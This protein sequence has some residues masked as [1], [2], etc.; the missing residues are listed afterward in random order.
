MCRGGSIVLAAALSLGVLTGCD[1]KEVI[2]AAAEV[3]KMSAPVD[4][5]RVSPLVKERVFEMFAS[6]KRSPETRYE[7]SRYLEES[8]LR[9][10]AFFKGA[11]KS[12]ELV[13]RQT[14]EMSPLELLDVATD[15][16]VRLFVR[17]MK[18]YQRERSGF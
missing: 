18:K 10:T 8:T 13:E 11:R 6:I 1:K 5:S 17:E 2:D 9:D 14:S 12:L 3:R 4:R 15:P 7:L 16:D